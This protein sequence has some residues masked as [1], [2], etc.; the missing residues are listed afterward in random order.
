MKLT[1][2]N[3]EIER[4][5]T[6]AEQ[7]EAAEL[8]REA[9]LEKAADRLLD[10]AAARERLAEIAARAAAIA[11]HPLLVSPFQRLCNDFPRLSKRQLKARLADLSLVDQL[12]F[13]AAAAKAYPTQAQR[14]QDA[15]RAIEKQ[16]AG[17]EKEVPA[18]GW[19]NDARNVPVKDG[20]AWPPGETPAAWNE[21]EGRDGKRM[22]RARG[23]KRIYPAAYVGSRGLSYEIE[24]QALYGSRTTQYL[25]EG[26]KPT[27]D[28]YMRGVLTIYD[29]HPSLRA[30]FRRKN[31]GKHGASNTID[32]PDYDGISD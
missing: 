28:G 25:S 30:Q 19:I 27:D 26:E 32:R 2:P 7:A 16:L 24:L 17:I 29:L 20:G 15:A 31:N 22:I 8:R 1:N 11:N 10:A 21:D 9:E 3:F 5:P 23:E 13:W 14:A 18:A 6:A 12:Q 4:E